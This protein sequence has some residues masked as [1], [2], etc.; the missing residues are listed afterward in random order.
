MPW[1]STPGPATVQA[2]LQPGARTTEYYARYNTCGWF[3]VVVAGS[4]I[5]RCSRSSCWSDK[6]LPLVTLKI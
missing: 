4:P 2:N 5:T 1:G 6:D 3:V